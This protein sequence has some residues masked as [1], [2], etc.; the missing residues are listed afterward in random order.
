M[1]AD[2]ILPTATPNAYSI[3][4]THTYLHAG[5]Y[6]VTVT[7]TDTRDNITA[8]SVENI[9][10]RQLSQ[11]ETTVAINP[12]DGSQIFIA[13]NDEAGIGL[14]DAGTGG[15]LFTAIS[16]DGGANWLPR[17]IGDGTDGLPAASSDPKAV[18]DDLGNLFLTYLDA[19]ATLWSQSAPMAARRLPDGT[20]AGSKAARTDQPSIATGPGQGGTGEAVW[21][22]YRG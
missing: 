6:P 20:F 14:A 15:G 17:I 9:S 7:V 22:T 8:N 13:S 21:V 5:A 1:A 3:I 19:G 11:S 12:K 18:F 2:T 16:T 10:Q 4:G